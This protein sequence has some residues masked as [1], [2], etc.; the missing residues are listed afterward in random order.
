[1]HHGR[2]APF[3]RMIQI[4]VKYDRTRGRAQSHATRGRAQ[5]RKQ[6]SQ[7]THRRPAKTDAAR[8]ETVAMVKYRYR[9]I[10]GQ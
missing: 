2:M 5:S 9:Y 1:M 7:R 10:F 6:R 8:G 3:L 4:T